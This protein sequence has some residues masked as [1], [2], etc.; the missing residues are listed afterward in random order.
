MTTFWI[1]WASSR[2]GARMRDWHSRSLGSS[3][4][5]VPMAKVA[6][7]PCVFM[8]QEQ[9]KENQERSDVCTVPNT[10]VGVWW[11]ILS[12]NEGSDFELGLSTRRGWL[13]SDSKDGVIFND[14]HSPSFFPQ[15]HYDQHKCRLS[16]FFVTHRTRLSLRNQ[17]TAQHGGFDSPLLNSRGFLKTVGINTT[18]QFFRNFHTIES[19]DSFIPVGVDVGISDAARRGFA[20]VVGLC[21]W[22]FT[23]DIMLRLHKMI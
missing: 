10:R 20:P 15:Y 4:A 7:L 14:R 6:V 2:V 5:R 1:C 21:R 9:E 23:V 17:I 22:L 11:S 13:F 3:L 16:T 12:K 18:K 8:C 19:I